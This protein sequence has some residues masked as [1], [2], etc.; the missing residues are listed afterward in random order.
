MSISPIDALLKRRTVRNY[1]PDPIPEE[2]MNKIMEAAKNSP[3]A[4]NYQG[5]DYIVVTNQQKLLELEKA[6]IASLDEKMKSFIDKRK[7]KHKAKNVLTCD[8]PC[9]VLIVKNE[10]ADERWIKYDAGIASMALM[11]AAQT[12]GIESM[13]IG[14]MSQPE[15]H[16]QCEKVFGLKDGALLLAVA[17]GKPAPNYILKEKEIKTKVTYIK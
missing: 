3:T 7:E 8:A 13:C 4:G 14:G 1:L 12:F 6:F 16:K 2:H 9:L 5:Y 10:R 17:L 11:I 15:T